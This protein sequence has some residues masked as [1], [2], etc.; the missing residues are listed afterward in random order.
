M[1]QGL[2]IGGGGIRGLM[3]TVMSWKCCERSGCVVRGWH[4]MWMNLAL[5]WVI[6]YA[7]SSGNAECVLLALGVFWG[8][9]ACSKH[10]GIEVR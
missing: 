1:A 8:Y 5:L 6:G 9:S 10:Q 4:V 3:T 2:G 7:V